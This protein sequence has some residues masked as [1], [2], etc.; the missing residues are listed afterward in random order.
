MKYIFILFVLSI[1]IGK[2]MEWIN[3]VHDPNRNP[4]KIDELEWYFSYPIFFVYKWHALFMIILST[5]CL[6]FYIIYLLLKYT[7]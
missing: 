5:V 1:P 6:P 2:F 4:T 3:G 7:I